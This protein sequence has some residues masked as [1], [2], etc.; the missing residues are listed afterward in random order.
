MAGNVPDDW[1]SYWTTCWD[2]G[3]HYH[4]SE[5]G[6]TRC[7]DEQQEREQAIS[8]IEHLLTNEKWLETRGRQDVGGGKTLA[9]VMREDLR[10]LKDF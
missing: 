7:G 9:E 2:C 10:R 6:C 4:A 8:N 1:E 3:A 5:G